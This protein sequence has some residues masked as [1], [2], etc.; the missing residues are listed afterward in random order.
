VPVGVSA[1]SGLRSLE[2]EALRT[3]KS[4]NARLPWTPE[5]PWKSGVW[6][7]CA[8]LESGLIAVSWVAL[9]L[10]MKSGA[11]ELGDRL[12]VRPVATSH[13]KAR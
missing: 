11:G 12:I 9:S 6:G 1:I 5:G 13:V 3:S 8:A 4:P 2:C 10:S 7:R